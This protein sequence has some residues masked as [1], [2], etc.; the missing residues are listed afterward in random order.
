MLVE[1]I[2]VLVE[3]IRVLV[4]SMK[5]QVQAVSVIKSPGECMKDA[6]RVIL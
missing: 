3:A 4:D 1:S 5:G 6:F 2:R